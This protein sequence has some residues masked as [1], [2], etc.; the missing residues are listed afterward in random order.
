MGFRYTRSESPG[1][2][3]FKDLWVAVLR[4]RSTVQTCVWNLGVKDARHGLL[5]PGSVLF[6]SVPPG[7]V[8]RASFSPRPKIPHLEGLQRIRLKHTMQRR[9]V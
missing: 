1:S 2:S 4:V 3:Q 6:Q 9:V 7:S 5:G 8:E